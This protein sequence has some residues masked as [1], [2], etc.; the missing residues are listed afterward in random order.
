MQEIALDEFNLLCREIWNKK[1]ECDEFDKLASEK[2]KELEELKTRA[3]AFMENSTIDKFSVKG[4]GNISVMAR[5]SVKVPAGEERQ[6]FFN[7]L[8]EQGTFENMVT[9]NSNTLNAWYQ[10]ELESAITRGDVDFKIPG[11][12]EP[13]IY[14][15]LTLRKG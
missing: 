11:I 15:T 14:K 5:S 4:F 10:Q 1:L 7:Y 12:E 13:K 3:L 2:K 9:V 6:K 8:R